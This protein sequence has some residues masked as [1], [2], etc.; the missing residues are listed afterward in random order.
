LVLCL[1][2]AFSFLLITTGIQVGLGMLMTKEYV[3][4]M[5]NAY[6]ITATDNARSRVDF[7]IHPSRFSAQN[8]IVWLVSLG[9]SSGIVFTV[10]KYA[11]NK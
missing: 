1:I 10:H 2:F 5:T 8:M 4:D 6:E 11:F 3:P 9:I 7:G